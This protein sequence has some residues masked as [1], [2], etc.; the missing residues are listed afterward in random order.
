LDSGGCRRADTLLE[1]GGALGRATGPLAQ[2]FELACLGED[3]K[4]EQGHAEHRGERCDRSDL[5][6]RAR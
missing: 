5:G 2:P 3:E 4:R 6:E 1:V